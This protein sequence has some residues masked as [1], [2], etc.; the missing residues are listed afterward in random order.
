[1]YYISRVLTELV[2][3]EMNRFDKKIVCT[4]VLKDRFGC[5]TFFIALLHHRPTLQIHQ[6]QF[7]FLPVLHHTDVVKP[8]IT[9]PLLYTSTRLSASDASPPLH[10]PAVCYLCRCI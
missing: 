1:M 8:A 2:I 7:F 4:D 9:L 6:Y 3:T 5:S 10:C